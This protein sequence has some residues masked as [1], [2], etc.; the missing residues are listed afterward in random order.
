M[1]TESQI[2]PKKKSKPS[3]DQARRA[4]L[5]AAAAEREA[6]ELRAATETRTDAEAK[7]AVRA[8]KRSPAQLVQ[9][10]EAARRQLAHTLDEIEARLNPAAQAKRMIHDATR[11]LKILRRRHPEYLVAGAL[12]VTAVAVGLV[13]LGTR[14]LRR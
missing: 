8:I 6:A 2:D 13:W 12:G 11:R 9:D 5:R 1:S 3:S 10:A 4:K 7:A 14:N